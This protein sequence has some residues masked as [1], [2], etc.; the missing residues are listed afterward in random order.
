MLCVN[1]YGFSVHLH[2]L[3]F[4]VGVFGLVFSG[5]FLTVVVWMVY[6]VCVR[7]AAI[8]AN[9][10]M[11]VGRLHLC[12]RPLEVTVFL[13]GIERML[14]CAHFTSGSCDTFNRLVGNLGTW[15]DSV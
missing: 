11:I 6:G 14:V 9:V 12:V 15:M 8:R 2:N 13:V 10:F 4:G 7:A 5:L 3:N 1:F